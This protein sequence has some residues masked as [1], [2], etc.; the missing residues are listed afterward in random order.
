MNI[1]LVITDMHSLFDLVRQLMLVHGPGKYRARE[2]RAMRHD[3]PVHPIIA[4]SGQFSHTSWMRGKIDLVFSA[5]PYE[6]VGFKI[7]SLDVYSE[8]V[9]F[10]NYVNNNGLDGGRLAS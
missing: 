9:R 4:L 7:G 2:I 3:G 10:L 6:E 5:N 1:E 8:I